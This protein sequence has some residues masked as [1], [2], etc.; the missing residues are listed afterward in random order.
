MK[1][2]SNYERNY[3]RTRKKENIFG[4]INDQKTFDGAKKKAEIKRLS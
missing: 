3:E 1:N 2:T 4:S